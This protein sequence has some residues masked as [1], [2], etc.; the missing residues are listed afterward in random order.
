MTRTR[1]H[2]R[3]GSV[4]VLALFLMAFTAPLVCLALDA[5]TTYLRCVHNDIEIRTAAYVAGAGVHDA[6]GELLRDPSWRAGFS[7]QSFPPGLGHTYS[8]TVEDVGEGQI[9]VT[10]ASRTAAGF[11]RTVTATL[12]GY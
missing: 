7:D 4:L 1:P 10:S 9:H 8:V 2:N 11:T 6:I 12:S 3:R 5:H